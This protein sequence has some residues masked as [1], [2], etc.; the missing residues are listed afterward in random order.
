MQRHE[1]EKGNEGLER[2][3]APILETTQ[4]FDGKDKGTYSIK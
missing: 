3:A 2:K 4:A 1:N